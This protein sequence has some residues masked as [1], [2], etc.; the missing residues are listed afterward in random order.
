MEL[1][2]HIFRLAEVKYNSLIFEKL[3]SEWELIHIINGP[4][5]EALSLF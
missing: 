1:S 5:D 4:I 2:W 3:A